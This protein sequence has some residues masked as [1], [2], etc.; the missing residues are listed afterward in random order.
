MAARRWPLPGLCTT[1][2]LGTYCLTE[3]RADSDAAA[4]TGCATCE[5]T[6]FIS[7]AGAAN[8]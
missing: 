5:G 3:P 6:E 1:A 7:G 2:Q 4:I 8:V